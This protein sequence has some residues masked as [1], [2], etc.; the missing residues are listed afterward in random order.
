[1]WYF[2]LVFHRFKLD[3]KGQVVAFDCPPENS[4]KEITPIEKLTSSG[5]IYWYFVFSQEHMKHVLFDCSS[6]FGRDK[7]CLS[8]KKIL[9]SIDWIKI[10]N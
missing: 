8:V 7:L 3:A 2:C 5:F 9:E 10:S 4:A 1:M 6:N